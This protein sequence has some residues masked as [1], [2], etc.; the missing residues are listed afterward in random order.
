VTAHET[1]SAEA[2]A[3][4]A[5]L[6]SAAQRGHRVGEVWMLRLG[7]RH[8]TAGGQAL[9]ALEPRAVGELIRAGLAARHGLHI[10]LRLLVVARELRLTDQGRRQW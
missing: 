7:Y 2:K 5:E 4:L 1:L 9:R 3:A 8:Y 10:N 6:A